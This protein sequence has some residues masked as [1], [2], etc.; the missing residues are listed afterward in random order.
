MNKGL[1]SVVMAVHNEK[2]RYLRT[3]FNSIFNQT[4]RNIEIIIVDDASDFSCKS[5]INDICNDKNY[6]KI[7]HNETNIGLTKSLNRGISVAEGEFVARM[8]ADD[9]SVRNRIEKQVAFLKENEIVDIVGTGVVSFGDK[10]MFISPAFGYSNEDAQCNLFFSSTLCHP[11]VMMRRSFL[12]KNHLTY[13]ENVKKGQDYDMWERAS[14]LGNLAVMKEVLLYYRI[15]SAQ[16]TSTGSKD[17][18]KTADMVRLRRLKRIGIEP[19]EQEYRCHQLLAS[20]CDNDIHFTEIE[21]W[22]DKVI[23][24]SEHIPYLNSKMLRRN[25][26]ARLL[27]CKLRNPAYRKCIRLKD[28]PLLMNL[29]ATRFWM[30]AKLNLEKLKLGKLYDE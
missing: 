20:G 2:E 21:K 4:Y 14:V 13:D 30:V 17:Q 8:D 1:V 12:A 18:N 29:T 9:Y 15:H 22:V 19:T 3:A 23:L 25:L 6:V 7:I 10:T 24:H 26:S 5:V 11:S 16:I 28:I 27:L